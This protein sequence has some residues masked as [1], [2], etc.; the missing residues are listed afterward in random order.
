M[1]ALP[2]APTAYLS[3]LLI[4]PGASVLYDFVFTMTSTGAA[5]AGAD[6]VTLTFSGNFSDSKGALNVPIA[7]TT[8]ALLDLQPTQSSTAPVQDLMFFSANYFTPA[9]QSCQP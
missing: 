7:N 3:P 4:S 5:I 1:A 9:A 6:T 2:G 8:Q